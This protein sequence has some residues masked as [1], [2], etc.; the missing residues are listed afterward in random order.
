[1]KVHNCFTRNKSGWEVCIAM[2]RFFLSGHNQGANNGSIFIII[3]FLSNKCALEILVR[4]IKV[5]TQ[6]YKELTANPNFNILVITLL[7]QNLFNLTVKLGSCHSSSGSDISLCGHWEGKEM[8][9]RRI[10]R[11]F[12]TDYFQMEHV[13]TFS[14]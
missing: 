2:H 5:S 8:Y 3:I 1:M 12:I 11:N 7:F 13:S 9:F 10:K 14:Q 4:M 6:K